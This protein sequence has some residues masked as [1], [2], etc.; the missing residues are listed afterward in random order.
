[1]YS[2]K[3]S[4]YKE[5]MIVKDR[6]SFKDKLNNVLNFIWHPE[7]KEVMGRDGESWA[8]ISLFFACFYM[9][10]AGMF[11]VMLAIFMAIID[12]RMPTYY[13]EFS[14]MWQQKVEVTHVGVNP[15][16]GFRPQLDPFTTLIRIKSSERN[17]SHPY[18]YMK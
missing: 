4:V 9:F 12:K 11:A 10:L 17:L 8:K 6:L 2:E 16:L 15:G 18:S 14:V 1:M 5:E 3:S 7:K 13:N